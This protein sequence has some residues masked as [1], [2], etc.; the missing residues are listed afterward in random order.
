MKNFK[1]KKS[2]CSVVEIKQKMG[3]KNEIYKY[4]EQRD[5]NEFIMNYLNYLIEE[6][7]DSGQIKWR[8]VDSDE[9]DFEK[10]K[11]KFIKRR[12]SSLFLDIFYGLLRTKEFCKTCSHI[13]SIKFNVFNILEIPL[14]KKKVSNKPLIINNLLKEFFSERINPNEICSHCKVPIKYKTSINSLP[15]CLMIYF[16][17]DYTNNIRNN[18]DIPSSLEINLDEYLYDKSLNDYNDYCYKLKGILFYEFS[19]INIS[20]YKSACL[21]NNEEWYYFDDHHLETDKELIIDKNE[22][23]ILLFYERINI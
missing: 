13:F 7:K 20:H 21:V 23:P 8:C 18:I 3:E 16:N 15:K 1:N 22:N 4:N 19:K 11:S 17:R 6:T 5:A 10:F 9:T 12:G 2:Y 14:N